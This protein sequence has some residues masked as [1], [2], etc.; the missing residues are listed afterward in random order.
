MTLPVPRKGLRILWLALDIGVSPAAFYLTQAAG[1][2]VVRALI[3]AATVATL[4]LAVGTVRTRQLDAVALTMIV[5]YA[6]ML[7]MA[8]ATRDPRLVLLRDPA[9]S[10]I[11]GLIFLASARTAVPVT[12]Y[13]AQR[14]HGVETLSLS[15]IR[16][17]R[18][19]T[20][21]WGAVLTG[22][23]ALRAALVFLLPIPVAAGVSPLLELIVLAILGGWT[24]RQHR[25]D[26]KRIA[27]AGELVPA[28]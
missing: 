22:E 4:W 12:A 28:R 18:R 27:E 1:F 8:L 20:G 21:L 19:R 13:L 11:T 23:S 25:R 16:G 24:Y 2:G 6:L 3:T 14:L 17:H 9:I 5:T 7:A 15:E 10:A 26:R